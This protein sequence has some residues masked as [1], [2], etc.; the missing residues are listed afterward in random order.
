MVLEK[1]LQAV[2]MS[3]CGA[4]ASDAYEVGVMKALLERLPH[5]NGEPF[6]PA[7]YSGS[8]FGG[9]NAAVMVS[10]AAHG[11]AATVRY[12]EE[13]WLEGLCSTPHRPNGVCRLRCDPRTFFDPRSWIPN[14]LAPILETA[15]DSVFLAGEF[16]ARVRSNFSRPGPIGFSERLSSIPALTPF[17]DMTPLKQRLR[18]YVDLE[19]IRNS[20]KALMV[21]ATDWA[22]GA[23]RIF[24]NGEM[25]DPQGYDVLQA[26]AAYSLTFPFVEIQG[27]L[28]AGA[29]AS[30]G[31][32]LRPVVDTWAPRA[33]R[34]T[35][36]TIY[37]APPIHEIPSEK[38][39]SLLGGFGRYFDLNESINIRNDVQYGAGHPPPVPP[40]GDHAA[41]SS[42]TIHNYR[43]SKVIVDWFAITDFDWRKTEGYIE[44]GYRDTLN[45]DCRAA[46]CTLAE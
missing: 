3:G 32:P 17:W 15:N 36:H 45:H 20:E 40:A 10:D 46:G 11:T 12:L 44:L 14:P 30:M 19:K 1:S 16:M 26:S 21:N 4:G 34:L 33:A 38:M 39:P 9:F 28:F 18:R 5:L 13:A 42:V 6:D 31:T 24:V 41:K 35:V 8:A 27:R 25:T 43:P 22:L 7:I 37:V 23:A 2:V 29:P